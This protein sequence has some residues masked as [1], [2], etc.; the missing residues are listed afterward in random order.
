MCVN[1]VAPQLES[2]I[3]DDTLHLV[4]DIEELLVRKVK[5]VAET[6]ESNDHSASCMQELRPHPS[7]GTG[8]RPRWHAS[9]V[10]V[11]QFSEVN[12]SIWRVNEA[13][14]YLYG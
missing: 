12:H 1:L 2:L 11:G 13:Q 4:Q 6:V 14:R 9:S 3:L 7:R 10:C 5:V 8:A